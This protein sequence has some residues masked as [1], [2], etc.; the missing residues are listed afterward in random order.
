[1][2]F[3]DGNLPICHVVASMFRNISCSVF[4]IVCLF[5]TDT[6][7]SRLPPFTCNNPLVTSACDTLIIIESPGPSHSISSSQD[8]T[9]TLKLTK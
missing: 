5:K 9:Q 2:R 3:V 7:Q 6:Y 1:M 4:I 8:E